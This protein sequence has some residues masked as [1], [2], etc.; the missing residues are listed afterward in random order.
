M[1]DAG[2]VRGRQSIGHLDGQIER[3][4]GGQR[5][6]RQETSK[7]DAVYQLRHDVRHTVVHADVVHGDDV[8]MVQYAGRL[9]FV[10]ETARGFG[11]SLGDHFDGDVA[12][13]T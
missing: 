5:R 3:L 8:R 13:E 10:G 7:R 12:T 2:G 4:P 6:A 9:G 1:H 11:A